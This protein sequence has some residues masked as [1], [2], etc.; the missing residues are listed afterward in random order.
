MFYLLIDSFVWQSKSFGF[1]G[2]KDKRAVSTQRV[3]HF[4]ITKSAAIEY[5]LY[6]FFIYKNHLVLP[7]LYCS[8]WIL[9]KMEF[10]AI[11]K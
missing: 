1:A 7:A 2:T 5:S 11:V 4:T 8:L 3:S 6:G 10:Y 9:I